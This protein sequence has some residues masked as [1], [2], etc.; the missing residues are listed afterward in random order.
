[1]NKLFETFVQNLPC[2][3]LSVSTR[4]SRPTS[5][6]IQV[7]ANGQVNNLAAALLTPKFGATKTIPATAFERM[8]SQAAAADNVPPV[9]VDISNTRAPMR[10]PIA[11]A[12]AV[13]CIQLATVASAIAPPNDRGR[14]NGQNIG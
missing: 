2:S 8:G 13:S 3:G 5:R 7:R 4:R 14:S 11:K 10:L 1:M 6:G 12:S 9:D